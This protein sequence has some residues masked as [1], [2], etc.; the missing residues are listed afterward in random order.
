MYTQKYLALISLIL[1][2]GQSYAQL[3]K[4]SQFS[5]LTLPGYM[6]RIW[7]GG[8]MFSTYSNTSGFEIPRVIDLSPS[9]GTMG[10]A[11]IWIGAYDENNELHMAAMTY[12]QRGIDYYPGPVNIDSTGSTQYYDAIFPLGYD[13]VLQQ[14]QSGFT[15]VSNNIKAWPVNN[16]FLPSRPLAPFYDKNK[17]GN[18][19]PYNGD[20]PL[21]NG[22]KALYMVFNDKGPHEETLG[23][24]L[25]VDVEVMFYGFGSTDTALN[26][27][28]F[29][30]YAITNRSKHTY[31]KFFIAL[32]VD[33]DI[34]NYADDYAGCDTT[35]NLFFGYNGDSQDESVGG[36][37]FNPPA[38]GLVFLNQEMNSF[39][40]YDNSLDP[41]HGNPSTALEFYRIMS[42]LNLNGSKVLDNANVPTNYSFYGNVGEQGQYNALN[43]GKSPDDIRGVGSAGP[44]T[45]LPNESVCLDVAFVTAF[46]RGV[47]G[48]AARSVPTLKRYTDSIQSY[49]DR[50]IILTR[51]ILCQNRQAV[52][53]QPLMAEQ[54]LQVYP[55]PGTGII[56]FS[57]APSEDKARV[58]I[59]ASDGRIVYSFIAVSGRQELDVSDLP[60]GLYQVVVVDAGR[61]VKANFIKE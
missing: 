10:A 5:D 48:P 25:E 6:A 50:G 23:L 43:A 27:T 18:Y 39:H 22:Q 38:Q 8:D 55:N 52:G 53:L 40:S 28:L 36:Y 17:D 51:N 13:E 32:W 59:Y 4:P 47:N 19:D 45:L 30:N 11:A 46:D 61:L 35:R 33:F 34:G 44:Y 20:Y 54:S 58:D 3:Y 9:R 7:N 29:V 15:N 60:A 12:R 42:G 1:A 57:L 24:P 16:I 41:V 37:G 26:N 2:C 49:Y 56:H 14:K 21:I 31:K